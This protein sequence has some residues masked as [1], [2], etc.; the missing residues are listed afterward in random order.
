MSQRTSSAL[1]TPPRGI[2][3]SAAAI[4]A[5][6]LV[7]AA[8]AGSTGSTTPSAEASTGAS[9]AP[10]GAVQDLAITGTEYAFAAPA[11]IPAGLTKVT[12]TNDGPVTFWLQVP[13]RPVG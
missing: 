3:W 12:L 13:P 8:C 1:A 2:R 9:D 11:S 6:A 10:A 7:V 4:A 5:V